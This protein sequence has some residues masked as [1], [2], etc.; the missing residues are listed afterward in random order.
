MTAL[1]YDGFVPIE[2]RLH[3]RVR[4]YTQANGKA[5]FWLVLQVRLKSHRATLVV[6]DNTHVGCD[7]VTGIQKLVL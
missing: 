2:Y 6:A 4:C 1:I 3:T 7:K 5:I